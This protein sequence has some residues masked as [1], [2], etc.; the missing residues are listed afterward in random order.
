M[1]C[2]HV[3]DIIDQSFHVTLSR[4]LNKLFV[5]QYRFVIVPISLF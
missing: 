5:E 2:L 3:Y 1:H 4:H